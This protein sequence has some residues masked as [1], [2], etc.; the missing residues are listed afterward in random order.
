MTIL[1]SRISASPIWP[2]GL[3]RRKLNNLLTAHLATQVPAPSDTY[4]RKYS[5][6]GNDC[7]GAFE[8]DDD[9]DDLD[10]EDIYLEWTKLDAW[11]LLDTPVLE[12]NAQGQYT[13]QVE[14][15]RFSPPVPTSWEIYL[16]VSLRHS[17]TTTPWDLEVAFGGFQIVDKILTGKPCNHLVCPSG[18]LN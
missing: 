3:E 18:P 14:S 12:K 4:Y 6:K 8:I 9:D 13:S 1:K 15:A 5:D 16:M 17:K 7:E 11:A 10:L 2:E